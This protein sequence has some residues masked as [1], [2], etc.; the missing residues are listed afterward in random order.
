M[1]F[2][3]R[4]VAGA[5]LLQALVVSARA[6]E[7]VAMKVAAPELE[8]IKAWINSDPLTLENPSAARDADQ[9]RANGNG[10]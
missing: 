6:Q 5:A 1:R 3:L 9:K 4:L 8:G 2:V 7:P 10:S